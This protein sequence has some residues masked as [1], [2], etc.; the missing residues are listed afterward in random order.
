[1]GLCALA[2]EQWLQPDPDTDLRERAFAEH[3]EGVQHSRY[4]A[5]PGEELCALLGTQGGLLGAAK[6]HHEDMCLLKKFAGEDFYR[7]IGT[8]VA[9][10]T[11]WHPEEK[12]GLPLA[13]MHAPI[14]GY[15][16]QLASGVDHFMTK[17]RPGRIFGRC[18][19]F[20]APTGNR[21]WLAG[22]PQQD[23]ARVTAENAGD[24]LFARTE[25]QTLSRLPQTGVIL[26]TIGVYVSPLS[27][28]STPNVLQL[29]RSV[30]SLL[31][32]EGERRAAHCFADALIRYS[33]ERG[34]RDG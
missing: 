32:G 24:T 5:E 16:E 14:Q 4:S 17:L 34:R 33:E 2:P 27:A 7:L 3:E 26:F 6:A 8:A 9:W 29:A 31:E 23:F 10:P 11:D 18:N 21:R 20:I 28:V 1:M 12:M 19:W 15:Q 13:Q 30:S 22:D 25:R